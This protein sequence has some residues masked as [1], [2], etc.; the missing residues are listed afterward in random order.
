MGDFAENH[1]LFTFLILAGANPEFKVFL[2]VGTDLRQLFCNW[3]V[4]ALLFCRT[5]RKRKR[6]RIF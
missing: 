1:E 2:E 5:I 4:Y 3:L 6:V